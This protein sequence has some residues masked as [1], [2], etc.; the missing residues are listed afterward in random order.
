MSSSGFLTLFA[1][2]RRQTDS[3]MVVCGIEISLIPS[4]RAQAVAGVI[5]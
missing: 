3:T 2:I 5:G 1:G 4:L